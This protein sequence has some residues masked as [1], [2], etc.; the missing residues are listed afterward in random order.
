MSVLE[1][2]HNVTPP[3]YNGEENTSVANRYVAITLFLCSDNSSN[4][5][6]LFL[7]FFFLLFFFLLSSEPK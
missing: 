4:K 5:R 7:P 2:Q 3:T 1:H 6:S